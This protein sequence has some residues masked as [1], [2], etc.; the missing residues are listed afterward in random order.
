MPVRQA[1]S[2]NSPLPVH[3]LRFYRV[4]YILPSFVCSNSF[5]FTLFTELPVCT[6]SLPKTELT[7]SSLPCPLLPLCFQ[8][9]P[10]IKFCN[11][12]VLIT[13]QIARG[14]GIPQRRSPSSITLI[15]RPILER[16]RPQQTGGLCVFPL[17]AFCF[18]LFALASLLRC[19]Y[20]RFYCRRPHPALVAAA[21]RRCF[22]GGKK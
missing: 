5:V 20:C 11:P 3:S 14:V 1:V 10:T 17:S 21:L 8:Q 9:L 2:Y 18:L 12:F 7:N 6:Y 15:R 19:F 22:R 4:P 13:L 16:T